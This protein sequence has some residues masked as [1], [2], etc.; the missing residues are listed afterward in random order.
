MRGI[1]TPSA[2]FLSNC[3]LANNV[4]VIAAVPIAKKKVNST[5]KNNGRL[6]ESIE[7]VNI[8]VPSKET[9]SSQYAHGRNA[10]MALVNTRGQRLLFSALMP[11]TKASTPLTAS[12]PNISANSASK[13][14]VIPALSLNKNATNIGIE[15]TIWIAPVTIS[16]TPAALDTHVLLTVTS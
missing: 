6:R 5:P 11:P 7:P 3:F 10:A 1:S 15:N 14:H 8:L 4:S 16:R 9:N 13:A 12:G 2:Y